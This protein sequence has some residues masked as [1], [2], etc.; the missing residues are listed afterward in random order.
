MAV[1]VPSCVRRLT[2]MASD[3]SMAAKRRPFGGPFSARTSSVFR[4]TEASSN[5]AMPGKAGESTR[6]E[7]RPENFRNE[8]WDMM[9]F[10]KTHSDVTRGLDHDNPLPLKLSHAIGSIWSTDG[11]AKSLS[12]AW[13]CPSRKSLRTESVMC[14]GFRWSNE[15]SELRRVTVVYVVYIVFTYVYIHISR[16]VK[17]HLGTSRETA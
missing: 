16:D 7:A 6:R 3:C 1:E 17:S 2:L 15:Q 11:G 14:D 4:W 12:G 9:W 5:V 10:D 8:T 13:K